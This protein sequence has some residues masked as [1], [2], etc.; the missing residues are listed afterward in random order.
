[1]RRVVGWAVALCILGLLSAAPGAGAAQPLA[2]CFWEGPIST[3][4]P[5]TRGFDGR[6][7]NFPEE[8]ATYWMARFRLPPGDRLVLRGRYAYARY[9]SLNAYSDGVPTDAL[10]DFQTGPD[11]G[12]TNP[13]I[14]GARRN[15]KARSY[16]VNVVNEQPPSDP[17]SRAPN[18]V[19]A[20]PER[21]DQPIELFYRVYEPNRGRDLTGGA[22][23]PQ[24]DRD[25]GEIND[26]DRS[27]PV[28]DVPPETW[29]A[30]TSAPGCDSRTN[31]AYN[32][33]RWERF[34]NLEF[35]TQGVVLEC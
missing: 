22:G 15:R 34:F 31:P 16:T 33:V 18:T 19:Y 28:E 23:L 5:S 12:S 25:C 10:A 3:K 6:Y 4:Q 26:S 21:P 27:I 24:Q 8:S 9:Q 17:A 13:F 7:F 2:T 11:P 35:A 1:M 30:A 32:P 14:T 20:A 29:R